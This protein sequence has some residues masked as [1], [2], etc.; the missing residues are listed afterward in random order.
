MMDVTFNVFWGALK[1]ALQKPISVRNWTVDSEYVGE[2]FTAQVQG[3][4]IYCEPPGVNVSKDDFWKIW[5]CWGQYLAGNVK[6]Q[7]LRDLPHYNTKYVISIL[8][9]LMES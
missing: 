3:N 6:R 1:L 4:S 9:H 2:D 7:E 8:H 5:Q